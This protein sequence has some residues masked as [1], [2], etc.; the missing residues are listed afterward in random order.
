MP[1][2]ISR[3]GRDIEVKWSGC[4]LSK[5]TFQELTDLNNAARGLMDSQINSHLSIA[6]PQLA[7]K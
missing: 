7:K 3:D 6:L 5:Y 1:P 2:Q 4:G